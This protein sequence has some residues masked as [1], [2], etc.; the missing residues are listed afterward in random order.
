MVSNYVRR[1]FVF[2]LLS[3]EVHTMLRQT[4]SIISILSQRYAYLAPEKDNFSSGPFPT[5][6]YPWWQ[7]FSWRWA[8]LT[9]VGFLKNDA[10][11][12]GLDHWFR[13]LGSLKNIIKKNLFLGTNW[14]FI[15]MRWLT[16]L[17]KSGLVKVTKFPV[18]SYYHIYG[19]GVILG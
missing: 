10:S 4:I 6:F 1:K 9:W 18:S 17:R 2:S 12:S 15:Y 8:N 5:R 11:P 14:H 13:N 19:W 7:V 3:L 16:N